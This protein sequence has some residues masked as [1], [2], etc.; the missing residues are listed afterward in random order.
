[1]KKLLFI[2]TLI[3]F[4]SCSKDDADVDY[5]TQNDEEIQAYLAANNLQAQKTSSGLYYIIEEQGT[6]AQATVEDRVKVAY[7]GYLTNGTIFDESQTGLSFPILQNLIPGWAEG[8]S[9]FKEGGKGKLLIPAHLAYGGKNNG[10]IPGGSVIIFDIELI[11]VNYVT[12]ND[13]QI[14][15]YLSD[16]NLVAEKSSTG[17]YYIIDEAGTGVQ[18]TKTDKVTVAYKGTF[19]NGTVFDQSNANGISFNLDEVIKGWTEGITYFKEGGSGTLIVPAHLGYGNL[20]YFTI[21]G[22]SVLLFDV[23]LIKVN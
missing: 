6:G 21:P 13:A 5:R 1:M 7:K 4:V 2:A 23:N 19:L 20:D 16:K 11:Y 8:I 15:S 22:G 9:L 12:E 3:L 18:P 17:L 14:Q 10:K